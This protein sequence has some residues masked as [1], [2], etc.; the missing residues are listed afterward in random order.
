MAGKAVLMMGGLGENGRIE[1]GRLLARGLV[2]RGANLALAYAPSAAAQSQAQEIQA[3]A[4]SRGQ[5]CILIPITLSTTP[6]Q[7]VRQAFLDLGG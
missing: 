2:A 7:I 5:V 1:N 3:L 6:Q 4:H